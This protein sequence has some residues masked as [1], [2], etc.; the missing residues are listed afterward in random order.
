MASCGLA[1]AL[2]T[3]ANPTHAFLFGNSVGQASDAQLVINGTTTIG[4][5]ACAAAAKA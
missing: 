1:L 4:S 2:A 5:A 3:G